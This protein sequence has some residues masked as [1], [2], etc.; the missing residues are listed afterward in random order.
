MQLAIISILGDK[1]LVRTTFHNLALVQ[2]AN[3]VGMLDGTQSVSHSHG[4]ASLHQL[5]E[6]ILYQT[7]ALCIECRGSL[8][9]DEDRRILQ[10]GT[11]DADT[12]AL[13][14]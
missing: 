1:F 12:L 13:T 10:D 3:L 6:S 5:F 8:V 11:G 2:H 7:L 4:G 14:S 9:E